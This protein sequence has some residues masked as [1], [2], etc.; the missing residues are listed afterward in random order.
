MKFLFH[1]IFILFAF[2]FLFS[3]CEKVITLDLKDAQPKVII[4]GFI[5]NADTHSAYSVVVSHTNTFYS[6]GANVPISN[7][8][9]I[10]EDIDA[11]VKDT[12]IEA[13]KGVYKTQKIKGQVGHTYTLQVNVQGTTYTAISKMPNP[14][15]LDSLYYQKIQIVNTAF[16]QAVPVFQDPKGVEN[17]YLFAIQVNDSVQRTFEPWDDKFTDGKRNSRP[18]QVEAQELFDG[19]D[20]LSLTMYCVEKPVYT[21][22]FSLANASGNAQSPGNPISNISNGALGYF[23]AVTYAQRSVIVP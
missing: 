2:L 18:V 16:V 1:P 10:V 3:A 4:E 20:T 15:S 13:A 7:A 22:F 14:V 19:K 11:H 23:A 21:F 8:Q 12:L 17:F 6:E 5:D 9:V